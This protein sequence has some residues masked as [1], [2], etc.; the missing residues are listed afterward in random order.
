MIQLAAALPSLKAEMLLTL[1]DAVLIEVPDTVP[2]EA[3]AAVV[4]RA[5]EMD[6]EGLQLTVTITTGPDWGSLA[7]I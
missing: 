6:F 3:A 1:H 4:R 7:S 5:M 2:V